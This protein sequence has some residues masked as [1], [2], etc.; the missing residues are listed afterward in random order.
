L[1]KAF[2][3]LET[4]DSSLVKVETSPRMVTI[5]S[6]DAAMLVT[7]FKVT[8]ENLQGQMTLAIPHATLDP[9]REK[10]KESAMG[11]SSRRDGLWSGRLRDELEQTEV[12]VSATLGNV[13]LQVRDIL[14][15]Q[16]GDIIDLE[17][18]PATPLQILVEGRCKFQA[19]AGL[20][21]GKKAA[22]IISKP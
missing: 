18:D 4:L 7:R 12:T 19:L 20:R 6:P 16:V 2:A 9:L 17:S 8:V 13:R 15:F 14:N 3:P 10:F 21:N 11:T 1:K 5:V 22:R